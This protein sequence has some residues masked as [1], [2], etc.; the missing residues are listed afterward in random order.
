MAVETVVVHDTMPNDSND[1]TLTSDGF[2]T[3]QAAIVITSLAY[4]GDNPTDATGADAGICIGF[5]DGTNQYC[6]GITTEN[7][8]ST[9]TEKAGA[10]YRTDRIAAFPEPNTTTPSSYIASFSCSPTANGLT[11]SIEDDNTDDEYYVTAIFFK[12]LTNVGI[13]AAADSST[14]ITTTFRSDMA[15]WIQSE[16]AAG[17]ADDSMI[18]FGVSHHSSTDTVTQGCV[19]LTNLDGQG[20][21]IVR[22]CASNSHVSGYSRTS[23]TPNLYA[24]TGLTGTAGVNAAISVEA[25]PT[26]RSLICLAIELDDPDDGAVGFFTS[27]TASSS[28]VNNSLS[29]T[30]QCLGIIAQGSNATLDSAPNQE[31]E[32]MVGFGDGTTQASAYHSGR[33]NNT[34]KAH[35]SGFDSSNII[36]WT[37]YFSGGSETASLTSLDDDGFTLTYSNYDA[38]AYQ[39]VFWAIKEGS[40]APE[41]SDATVT[42]ITDTTAVIGCTVTF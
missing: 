3:V 13:F 1:H 25:R 8:L 15:F 7:Q 4:S 34:T 39:N 38:T 40:A 37:Q 41:L 18:S 27:P 23:D 10:A 16:G 14:S 9:S 42:S 12:G 26:N 5:W 30:P 28:Y 29:W 31:H 24:I 33:G 20:T 36:D 22:G 35:K 21:S 2:G 11:L 19:M 17:L 6:T 32:I